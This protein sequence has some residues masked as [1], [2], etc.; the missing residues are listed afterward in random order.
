[1]TTLRDK[2]QDARI[3]KYLI[4]EGFD[5]DHIADTLNYRQEAFF[6]VKDGKLLRDSEVIWRPDIK[7]AELYGDLKS[8]LIR[9]K[10]WVK[11]TG[12]KGYCQVTELSERD[13]KYIIYAYPR[14]SLKQYDVNKTTIF[15]IEFF[16]PVGVEI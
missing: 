2:E 4:D 11:H 12:G 3:T 13:A 8:I 10:R 6:Q 1:M 9:Q 16:A 15:K 14:Q 7:W 5:I